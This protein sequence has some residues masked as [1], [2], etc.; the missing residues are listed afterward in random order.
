M[1]SAILKTINPRNQI[2][3]WKKELA[4][5]ITSV[6]ELLNELN[7]GHLS[8]K[9]LHDSYFRLRVPRAY[10]AKMHKGDASD[11]LLLQVLPA[12]MENGGSG[13]TDPVGDL[14]AMITPGLLHKYHGRALLIATGACAIHCRYCFRR[15][16]PYS[17]ASTQSSNWQHTLDYLHSHEAI[18]EVILSGGDPLVLD[19]EKLA[20]LCKD[21]ESIPHLKWLRLHT[22]LPVVLPSR[23][24]ESLLAW[25]K[26]SRFRITMVIHANHANELGN[27]ERLALQHLQ[28]AGVTLLNQSV[29]LRGV[30]DSADNLIALS[31]QLHDCGV[32]PYYLHLLDKVQGAMHFDVDQHRAGEIMHKM[33]A[34]LPGFLL[35]RLVREETGASSKTAIFSI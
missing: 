10:V 25:M 2:N 20:Q 5:S 19:D 34:R 11:P 13:S 21:L 28:Q 8:D 14:D 1:P 26:Q 33:R 35:P 12:L 7:L 6:S 3:S 31:H 4:A 32:I 22:R 16:Y 24:N 17:E 29:L 15:H 23:I 30:N 9:V 27:T 18:S